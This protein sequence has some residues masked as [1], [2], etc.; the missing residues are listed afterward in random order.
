MI[1]DEFDK[2]NAKFF[3]ESDEFIRKLKM[4]DLM[5]KMDQVLGHTK[6]LEQDVERLT[7]RISDMQD[8]I[9]TIKQEVEK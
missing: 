3:S 2:I 7:N 4:K 6:N 9:D 1:F 5:S 8:D